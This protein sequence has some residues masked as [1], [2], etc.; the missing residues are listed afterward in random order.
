M[1][2]IRSHIH[3][4]VQIMK[5]MMNTCPAG[6]ALALFHICNLERQFHPGKQDVRQHTHQ[7]S[8]HNGVCMHCCPP[9]IHV[10]PTAHCLDSFVIGDLSLADLTNHY[11]AEHDRLLHASMPATRMSACSSCFLVAEAGKYTLL[12]DITVLADFMGAVAHLLS[13]MIYLPSWQYEV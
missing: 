1:A 8:F 3:V 6:T 5:D 13:H 7:A 4:S 11:K 10:L 12:E 9:Q 2:D